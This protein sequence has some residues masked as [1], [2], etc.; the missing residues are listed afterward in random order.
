MKVLISNLKEILKNE[1]FVKYINGE[2]KAGR[3]LFILSNPEEEELTKKYSNESIKINELTYNMLDNI[4]CLDQNIRDYL[5]LDVFEELIEKDR[6]C[7]EQMKNIL[8]L[9][10]S[11]KHIF[12]GEGKVIEVLIF[13]MHLNTFKR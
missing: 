7:Y 9:C 12:Y 1:E 13:F 10:L 6:M 11:E 2:Y 4:G 8:K 5:I 3:I